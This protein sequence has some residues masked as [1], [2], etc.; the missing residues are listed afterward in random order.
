MLSDFRFALRQLVKSPGFT[1]TVVITLA[2]GISACVT[3]LALIDSVLLRSYASYSE[4]SVAIYHTRPPDTTPLEV[5]HRAWSAF[6]SEL[7]SFELSASPPASC[8]R[9]APRKSIR[10]S[11]CARNNNERSAISIQRSASGDRP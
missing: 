3:I 7:K 6:S 4:R 10:S 11:R 8:R 5:L 1:A 9:A 2:L